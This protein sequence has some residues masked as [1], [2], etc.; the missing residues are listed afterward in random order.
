ME[1]QALA[2][3]RKLL[4]IKRLDGSG[5]ACA[6]R[7]AFPASPSSPPALPAMPSPRRS[8]IL[9]LLLTAL[10]ACGGSTDPKTLTEEGYAALGASD[11]AGALAEFEAALAEIGADTA[12]PQFMRAKLGA[13]EA[14]IR[15]DPAAAK[16]EFLD[17]AAGM[18]SKVTAKDFS[19]FGQRFAGAGEY[20]AAVDLLDAGM[21]AHA[22]S[23][24]LKQ[25]QQAIKT[26]AEQAGATDALEKMRGLGYI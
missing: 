8:V 18:P 10:P 15:L 3:G 1:P 14:R 17:L 4:Q 24:D 22:E 9:L 21:K 5:W 20:M 23:P 25:L 16:Q 7:V 13:I 6:H 19:Y 11:S 2:P 26:A 12:H